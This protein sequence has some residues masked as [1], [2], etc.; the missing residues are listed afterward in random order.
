MRY[1]RR[2]GTRRITVI[3][4][5]ACSALAASATPLS[6]GTPASAQPTSIQPIP[7]KMVI[8][9]A[10]EI[11][12]DTGDRAGEYQAWATVMPTKI[13]FPIGYR[14][15]R[16]DPARGVLLLSTGMGT[17]RAAGSTMALGLDP[18]FDLRKAYWMVAAIAGVNPNEASVGSAAWIGNV[19]DS[20]YGYGVDPREMP[21]G[22][23]TGHFSREATA[24]YAEPKGD[25]SYNL[26]PLNLGLRDWAYEL[27]KSVKLANPAGLDGIRKEFAAFPRTQTL[28]AVIK[29]DEVTGQLFWHG[30]IY[31][32]H[33]EKW[34]RYWVGAQGRFVMTGM[35]D[36]GV[37]ASLAK[38]GD[39][40]LADPKRLL[41]LRTGSNYSLPAPGSGLDAA[42]DLTEHHH[43][44]SALQPS[45]DAAFAV[46]SKVV[47]E[48]TSHWDRYGN[49]VP[50]TS[51]NVAMVK[52]GL[53][54]GP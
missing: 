51:S 50:G 53:A 52:G 41:V 20:D 21:K 40:G 37:V 27:T 38:L 33:F 30:A 46:G 18:R 25:T 42:T 43:A 17:N 45:L 49:S 2:G 32:D 8:V 6:A 16:I 28:P 23:T 7:I 13:A 54:A 3:I 11:G 5:A 12:E 22:W 31:N 35:E 9:T 10:F 19:V 26:F 48:I 39:V 47:D 14:D 36:S 1:R 4:L 29:G 15:L 24:P 34:T 44:Y